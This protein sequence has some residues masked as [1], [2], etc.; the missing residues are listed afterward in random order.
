M[1]KQ[2]VFIV[3]L[4]FATLFTVGLPSSNVQATKRVVLLPFD[5]DDAK[6]S[7]KTIRSFIQDLLK[8]NYEYVQKKDVKET[9][10]EEIDFRNIS[11]DDIKK[12]SNKFTITAWVGAEIKKVKFNTFL[13]K[14]KIYSWE[15]GEIVEQKEYTYRGK[16]S[17][18]QIEEMAALVLETI[19][20]M[21]EYTPPEEPKVE[22]SAPQVEEKVE[23]SEP[24]DPSKTKIEKTQ[25]AMEPNVV[26][27]VSAGL[28][29]GFLIRSL[30]FSPTTEPYYKTSSPSFAPQLR[31]ALY[32]LALSGNSNSVG[33]RIGLHLAAMF[34]PAFKSYPANDQDNEVG[35][36]VFDINAALTFR[37][38]VGDNVHII[39][40]VG[41]AMRQWTFAKKDVL[42][43]PGVSYS[44]IDLGTD[45][46]FN[47]ANIA[48]L[49]TGFS[50]Y[51]PLAAGD[52]AD[53]AY[54]GESSLF[55]MAFRFLFGYKLTPQL[56]I[57]AMF[58]YSRYQFSFNDKGARQA[59][60]AADQMMQFGIGARF[61]H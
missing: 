30:D 38:P 1:Q 8:N 21:K 27:A 33:A 19:E 23:N 45:V 47:L 28:V 59:D 22:V 34:M 50:I 49:E 16:P 31:L 2:V 5:A 36:T 48:V 60:S 25:K 26:P 41:Y 17:Q 58:D 12:L 10:E 39:P 32:P 35:T 53:G 7:G 9:V 56:E 51:L 20:S 15:T 61:N 46:R 11:P 54:Y 14:T 52:L 3:F 4:F 40:R 57:V 44:S 24:L 6:E 43:V 13:F 42:D 18:K 55:G 37:Q 29:F